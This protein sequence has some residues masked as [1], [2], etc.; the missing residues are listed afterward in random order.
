MADSPPV[1]FGDN[2]RVRVTPVT[3]SHGVAGLAGTVHGWTTPS[4]TGVTVIGG[5]EQDYAV[6]V[7]FEQRGDVWFTPELLDF[8]DHGAGQD[9]RV[10]DKQWVRSETGEWLETAKKK[11]WWRFW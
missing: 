6:A 10:G 7:H 3:E 11:A 4:V 1:S 8:L 5:V 2:V 9:I